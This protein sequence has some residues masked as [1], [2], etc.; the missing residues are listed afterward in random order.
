[1]ETKIFVGTTRVTV[2]IT[3]RIMKALLNEDEYD[4][5]FIAIRFER[6][7]IHVKKDLI[8]M[9]IPEEKIKWDGE[10]YFADDWGKKFWKR[11]AEEEG[12]A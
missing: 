12:K 3:I 8:A 5:V 10:V 4:S 6:I 2:V 7:A 1:M 9:G 11:K